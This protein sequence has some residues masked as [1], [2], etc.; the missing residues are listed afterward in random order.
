MFCHRCHRGFDTYDEI[1]QHWKKSIPCD[2][3]CPKCG[4]RLPSR[5]SYYLHQN[6][7]CTDIPKKGYSSTI[8]LNSNN[9][10]DLV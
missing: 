9:K 3:V 2:Y 6:S 8:Q 5:S 1:H 4:Y 10:R 7:N